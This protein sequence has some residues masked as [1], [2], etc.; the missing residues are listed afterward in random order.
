MAVNRA[1]SGLASRNDIAGSSE[2]P[3]E[4]LNAGDTKRTWPCAERRSDAHEK[5]MKGKHKM[6]TDLYNAKAHGAEK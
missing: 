1:R 2:G 4:S 3:E 6:L 5:M